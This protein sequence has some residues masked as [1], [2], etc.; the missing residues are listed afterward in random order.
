MEASTINTHL[1]VA[2]E[3]VPASLADCSHAGGTR[4]TSPEHPAASLEDMNIPLMTENSFS[5]AR[6]GSSAS[7][8][9]K[10]R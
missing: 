10:R 9:S 8:S 7:E 5:T 2:A 4:M 1:S 3:A 6:D